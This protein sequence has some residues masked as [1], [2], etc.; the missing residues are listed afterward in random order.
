MFGFDTFILSGTLYGLLQFTAAPMSVTAVF[1]DFGP[2]KNPS[3]GVMGRLRAGTY[4][5]L[6]AESCARLFDIAQDNGCVLIKAPPYTGKTSQLQ[7]LMQWLTTKG[8]CVAYVT[9][10]TLRPKDNVLDFIAHHVHRSWEDIAA[11]AT[12]LVCNIWKQRYH[13]FCDTVTAAHC[14]LVSRQFNQPCCAIVPWK[15]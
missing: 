15:L 2:L 10:L 8:Y 3:E 13:A 9:F 6:R 14:C 7:L 4:H 11:G 5:T 1:A 12:D